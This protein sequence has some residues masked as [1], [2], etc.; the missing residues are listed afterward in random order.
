M[1]VPLDVAVSRVMQA[2]PERIRRVMFDPQQ[3]P[4]WMSAV[5]SVERLS[6]DDRPGA[7]VRR[8]GRFMG[9]ELRWTTETV[10]ALRNSST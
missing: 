7:R 4:G 9:R 6:D 10:R 5:K 8:V 2:P 3:D 1:G